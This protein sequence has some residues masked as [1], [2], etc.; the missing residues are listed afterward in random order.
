MNFGRSPSAFFLGYGRFESGT[1]CLLAA[2]RRFYGLVENG[3][4]ANDPRAFARH[5]QARQRRRPAP[6]PAS[7]NAGV[8]IPHRCVVACSP[9]SW[10][11]RWRRVW[12]R[13]GCGCGVTGWATLCIGSMTRRANRSG[14]EDFGMFILSGED[15][16]CST[17][18]RPAPIQPISN[19]S[20]ATQGFSR[21]SGESSIQQSRARQSTWDRNMRAFCIGWVWNTMPDISVYGRRPRYGGSS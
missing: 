10:Q 4:Y 6:G 16:G 7:Y 9:F 5:R 15:S 20:G 11:C 14:S 13:R 12:L 2:I 21:D 8:T 3:A 1:N 18:D 19:R 17:C